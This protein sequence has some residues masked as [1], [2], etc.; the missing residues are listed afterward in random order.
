MFS[1][2][3]CSQNMMVMATR[4]LQNNSSNGQNNTSVCAFEN[5]VYFTVWN[6]Q[7][8]CGLWMETPTDNY[9]FPYL[10]S[11]AAYIHYAEVGV[12]HWKKI[13][14]HSAIHKILTEK[15]NSFFNW[16]LPLCYQLLKVPN[17][18]W[19]FPNFWSR[20]SDSLHTFQTYSLSLIITVQRK[21]CSCR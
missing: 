6:H 7:N 13:W 10:E 16:C 20:K 11:N 15:M 19:L 2:S 21:W 3:Y 17:T 8:L 1:S 9:L 18:D 5:F 12:W 14:I 4:T